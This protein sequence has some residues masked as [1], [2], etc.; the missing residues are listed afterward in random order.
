VKVTS[1]EV[2]EG[3]LLKTNI[4]GIISKTSFLSIPTHSILKEHHKTQTRNV[5]TLEKCLF[6]T[7]QLLKYTVWP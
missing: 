2:G 7:G 3:R 5:D 1:I 4:H 6:E